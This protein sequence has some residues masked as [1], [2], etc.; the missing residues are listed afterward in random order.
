MTV[1]P[2]TLFSGPEKHVYGTPTASDRAN[3]TGKLDGN[4]M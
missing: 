3:Q 4:G 2:K 1:N